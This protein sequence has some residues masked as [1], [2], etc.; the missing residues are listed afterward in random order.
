MFTLKIGFCG[1]IFV[2]LSVD[3]FHAHAFDVEEQLI[4][5][6]YTREQPDVYQGL[7]AADLTSTS[8]VAFNP[9]RPTRI[10]IHGFKSK[11]K[12]IIRYKDAYL[13]LGDY[14]FIGVDWISGARTYN[15]LSAKSRV[16]PV[17]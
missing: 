9:N 12:V 15:Y 8:P 16:I 13:K 11:E 1:I 2:L 5:R 10:F 7:K 17:S 3:V 6:L 4:F 14:N